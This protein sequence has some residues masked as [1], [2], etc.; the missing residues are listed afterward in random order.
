MEG[1]PPATA[2]GAPTV[3]APVGV[4]PPPAPWRRRGLH[5][6]R[7]G[8]SSHGAGGIGRANPRGAAHGAVK[9]IG[10]SSPLKVLTLQKINLVTQISKSYN[11]TPFTVPLPDGNGGMEGGGLLVVAQEGLVGPGRRHRA[12]T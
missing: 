10:W 8:G 9:G 5:E 7:G 12:C 6:A 11:G 1:G 2:A 4:E 3:P